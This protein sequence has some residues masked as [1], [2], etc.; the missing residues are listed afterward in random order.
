[1]AKPR[2]ALRRRPVLERGRGTMDDILHASEQVFSKHGYAHGTTNR[3]AARAGVAIGSVYQYFPN[4]DSILVALVRR[5]MEEGT[6]L[7]L[8]ML[9]E[10]P[11]PAT[12]PLP[13]LVDRFVRAM[14]ALHERDP[15]LHRV[16]FEEAPHPKVLWDELAAM[17]S[18]ICAMVAAMLE[19]HP[20]VAI[21]DAAVA[22]WIVVQTVESLVHRFVIH[23][24]GPAQRERFIAEVVEMIAGY[25][26]RPAAGA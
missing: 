9:A 22:S 6:A 1:M 10:E 25:L 13:E 16:L 7:V 19:A 3:I 14:V 23:G 2:L 26:G 18:K 24:P 20:A 4:K 15:K 17:E 8:S 21:R 11:A 5:H 12:R